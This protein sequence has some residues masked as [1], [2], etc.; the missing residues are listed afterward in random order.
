MALSTFHISPGLLVFP[1][2]NNINHIHT[3]IEL[4]FCNNICR[5]FTSKTPWNIIG[6][7]KYEQIKCTIWTSRTLLTRFWESGI[8]L[9]VYYPHWQHYDLTHCFRNPLPVNVFLKLKYFITLALIL[10]SINKFHCRLCRGECFSRI[11]KVQVHHRLALSSQFEL[12]SSKLES[13]R[14]GWKSRANDKLWY[15]WHYWDWRDFVFSFA[16]SALV[17]IH[18]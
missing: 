6:N 13:G 4:I 3:N 15:L 18:F 9:T 10:I 8:V 16:C 2:C 1:E 12:I 7:E 17:S 11:V 14:N 5:Q